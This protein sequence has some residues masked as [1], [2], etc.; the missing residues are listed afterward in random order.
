MAGY[1]ITRNEIEY[2]RD[3]IK[4]LKYRIN[5]GKRPRRGNGTAGAKSNRQ[6]YKCGGKHK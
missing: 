3:R 1:R 5:L 4:D 2:F 6:L